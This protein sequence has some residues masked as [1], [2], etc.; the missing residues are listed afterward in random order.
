MEIISSSS[1]WFLHVTLYFVSD[2]ITNNLTKNVLSARD[3]VNRGD[4][5]GPLLKGPEIEIVKD[6]CPA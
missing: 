3:T 4:V 6:F 1:S 5:L 2:G